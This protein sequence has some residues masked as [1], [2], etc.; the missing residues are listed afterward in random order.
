MGSLGC[1]RDV[2]QAPAAWWEQRS[3]L[4]PSCPPHG[5]AFPASHCSLWPE[6]PSGV[7]W[8]AQERCQLLPLGWALPFGSQ[9]LPGTCQSPHRTLTFPG[10]CLSLSLGLKNLGV[11]LRSLP[12]QP[13]LC[14][15]TNSLHPQ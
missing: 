13:Y 7:P 3:P 11:T 9:M 5:W 10:L 12:F 15:A 6:G 2:S 14:M 4:T 1:P 8:L